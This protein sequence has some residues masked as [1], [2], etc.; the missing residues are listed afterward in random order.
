MDRRCMM[1]RKHHTLINS[2]FHI[3][4]HRLCI[5]A[6]VYI[7]HVIVIGTYFCGNGREA[8]RHKRVVAVWA[9]RANEQLNDVSSVPCLDAHRPKYLLI[10]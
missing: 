1:L 3:H 8:S 4:E 10:Y 9:H 5:P 6:Y 2:R 7:G